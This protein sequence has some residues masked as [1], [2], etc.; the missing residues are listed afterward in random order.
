MT[1]LNQIEA[2]RRNAQRS[3]GPSTESGRA[4]SAANAL[5]HG[6]AAEKY[7]LRDEDKAEFDALHEALRVTWQPATPY[8]E[9][10][11]LR[12]AMSHW[13]LDRALRAEAGMFDFSSLADI[14]VAQPEGIKTLNSYET[15][16]R[17]SL[18]LHIA[19]LE[20]AQAR[21]RGAE[22]SPSPENGSTER[23]RKGA[24]RTTLP[25]TPAPMQNQKTNPIST[26]GCAPEETSRNVL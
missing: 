12:I 14:F 21:R 16:I 3:T 25:E 2:N 23:S 18:K 19:G 9:I 4:T 20:A 24:R 7:L 1:T 22:A 5:K 17:K 6:L 8:E 13:R 10:L 15:A 11:V 26:V